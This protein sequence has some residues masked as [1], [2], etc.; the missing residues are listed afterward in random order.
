MR[1]P[2][3]ADIRSMSGDIYAEAL[4]SAIRPE[5]DND[6][7]NEIRRTL[8]ELG[9]PPNNQTHLQACLVMS[10]NKPARSHDKDGERLVAFM[11]FIY[12]DFTKSFACRQFLKSEADL[13]SWYSNKF[14]EPIESLKVK[15]EQ[16]GP[17]NPLTKW[18]NYYVFISVPGKEDKLVGV[19]DGKFAG[20]ELKMQA[21]PAKY[22]E[23]QLGM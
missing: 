3:E 11:A 5:D 16:E 22:R 19:M 4:G 2:K 10:E 13:L 1:T 9:Y 6:V 18:D 15:Y 21:K 17:C 20:P 23:Q 8:L 12:G 14:G 7:L